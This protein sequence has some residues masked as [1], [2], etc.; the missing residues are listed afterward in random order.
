MVDE[1][2]RADFSGVALE[3]ALLVALHLCPSQVHYG[4]LHLRPFPVYLDQRRLIVPLEYLFLLHFVQV[5]D[6]FAETLQSVEFDFTFV[7]ILLRGPL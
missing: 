6:V 7:V 3:S 5:Q 4:L 1:S 2:V